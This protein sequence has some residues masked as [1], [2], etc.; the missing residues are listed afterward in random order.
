[1]R[2]GRLRKG[3]SRFLRVSQPRA[4]YLRMWWGAS[5]TQFVLPKVSLL[6]CIDCLLSQLVWVGSFLQSLRVQVFEEV[7]SNVVN[8]RR[9]FCRSRK[10]LSRGLCYDCRSSSRLKRSIRRSG[11]H[12]SVF[13]GSSSSRHQRMFV[14][15]SR[16]LFLRIY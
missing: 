9:L 16:N 8:L 4:T 10:L 13:T 3:Y 1:M 2:P 15:L 6:G 14:L 11:R 5:P 7:K 12:L